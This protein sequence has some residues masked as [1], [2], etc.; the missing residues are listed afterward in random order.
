MAARKRESAHPFETTWN[1]PR[2]AGGDAGY[3]IVV[4]SLLPAECGLSG[5]TM[6]STVFALLISTSLTA[7]ALA[8]DAETQLDTIDVVGLRPVETGD[9]SSS[10][11]LLSAADLAVRNSP[12]IADQLRGVPGLGVSRSGSSGGLTQ[13]R[14]RGAEANHTLV[15]LNGIEISDPVTGETDF[16][17]LQGL[18]VDRVEVARGEHSSLYGSDAIGGVIALLTTSN[19]KPMASTE[20]GTQDTYRADAAIGGTIGDTQLLGALSAFSTAGVDTSGRNGEKDGSDSYSAF[21]SVKQDLGEMGHL[22]GLFTYRTSTSETDPDLDYDGLLDNA[23]RETVSDQWMVGANWTASA[24]GVDHQLNASFNSVERENRADGAETDNTTGERTKLSYS[25]AIS[26]DLS[27][28]VLGVAGLID[29]ERED[30]ERQGVASFFGDPNQSQTFETLGV[31]AEARYDIDALSLNASIRRDDN[32]GRFDDAT[33]WRIGAAYDLTGTTRVRASTGEGTKNPTFTELFGY[34]PGS[35]IGNPDLLPESS[36]SWEAGIDQTFGPLSFSLTYFEADLENEIYTAYTPTFASTPM[37]RTG[38]SSRSGV[39]LAANWVLNQEVSLTG[40]LSNISSESDTGADEIRVPDW[41]GSLAINWQSAV[42]EGFQAG[43]ALDYVGD[44]L[45]TDFGTF[46]T[47]TL[48]EYVL[49]S[50]TFEYPISQKLSVTLR[51]ENLLDA[52]VQDV[53]GYHAPGAAA[54]IGL[55]LR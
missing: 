51:G 44:Q 21:G 36:T 19:A 39:E 13:I 33:T 22:S 26:Y 25:P 9:V 2:R 54:F 6:R 7:P 30:Y 1:A 27:G 50:G 46:Q 8:L 47:V 28:G 14:I 55:K 16:G 10:V 53:F 49:V 12:Y 52:D 41:T 11:T 34:Y 45:D 5:N 38:D 3:L 40:S 32:D 18:P 35:F 20:I 29:W 17:L 43:L 42:T 48:D 31:A 15:L 24:F 4:S 37:N 23:D